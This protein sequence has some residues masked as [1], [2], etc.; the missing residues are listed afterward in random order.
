MLGL[1]A[2]GPLPGVA[3]EMRIRLLRQRQK[4][5]GMAHAHRFSLV[6]GV[7]P[8]D[9]KV[10]DRLQHPEP[11]PGATHQALVD[12]GLEDVEIGFGNQFGRL[13]RPPTAEHGEACKEPSLFCGEQ[14]VRPFDR[15]PQGVLSGI[16][17]PSPLQ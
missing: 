13:Q 3:G 15:C 8:F 5:C 11:R 7:E 12:E 2:I 14:L 6:G 4:V 17:V 1:E 16:G 10:A 9:G